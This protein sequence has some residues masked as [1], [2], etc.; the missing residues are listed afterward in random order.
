MHYANINWA[1]HSHDGAASDY[2]ENLNATVDSFVFDE[3]DIC[4]AFSQWLLDVRHVFEQLSIYHHGLMEVQ[5]FIV[6]IETPLIIACTFGLR[7]VLSNT[8]NLGVFDKNER[9][10]FD[11]SDLYFAAY[12]GHT[13]AR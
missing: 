8:L 12:S 2:A 4:F 10:Y 13:N 11:R 7:Q 5:A 1:Q 3:N 6:T 9:T